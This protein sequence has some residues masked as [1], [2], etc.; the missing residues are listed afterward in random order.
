[1]Q[2]TT[3]IKELTFGNYPVELK[4]VDTEIEITCKGVTGTFTQCDKYM[5]RTKGKNFSYKFGDYNII[6][7]EKGY[8]IA[9]LRGS[10][11]ES[12]RIIA[13]CKELLNNQ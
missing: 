6:R 8:K 9:C 5:K 1:M 13:E 4:L 12:E 7:T 11:E 3:N 10:L 2:N